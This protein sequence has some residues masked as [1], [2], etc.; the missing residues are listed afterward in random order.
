MARKF[1]LA[2]KSDL[3]A[4][5]IEMYG[6]QLADVFAEIVALF[7]EQDETRKKALETKFATETIP[8]NMKLF[9]DRLGKTGSGYFAKS[10]LSWADLYLF[11]I[12][13]NL[14]D[15]KDAVLANFKNVKALD[16]NIR[17]NP[18]IAAWL[19]KRPKTDY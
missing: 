4:A 17:A 8:H 1:G 15:K 18:R 3:E 10:G 13:D 19:A 9:N 16:E 14:G 12:L 2:G 7:F 11:V 6:D 5:E